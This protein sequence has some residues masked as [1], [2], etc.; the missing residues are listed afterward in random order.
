MSEMASDQ[1]SEGEVHPL[2][3]ESRPLPK[4]TVLA[5]LIEPFDDA[6]WE[7]S[8]GQDVV[9]LPRAQ[10]R[11][12]AAAAK[13][14]GFEMCVDVTAVDHHRARRERFELV[15]NLVSQRHG[16]RLR[17]RLIIPADDPTVPSLVSIYPGTNFF[18]REVFDMFGIS[19]DDHPDMTRILM[20]DDWQGHPLRKDFGV[21]SVPVQFK[22]SHQ[23]T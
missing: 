5:S 9:V 3:V 6:A 15:V 14:A 12:F 11:D 10:L 20:P 18:E 19:F 16:M 1:E 21:G 4:A 2:V 13:A 8:F 7:L 22:E 17:I 23:V